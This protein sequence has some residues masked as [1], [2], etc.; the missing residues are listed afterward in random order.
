M[1]ILI[2]SI[3]QAIKSTSTSTASQTQVVRGKNK[4]RVSEDQQPQAIQQPQASQ[5]SQ[6]SLKPKKKISLKDRRI[7]FTRDNNENEANTQDIILALNKALY[8]LGITVQKGQY[9]KTKQLSLELVEY[10]SSREFLA[11]KD[12]VINIVR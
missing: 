7:L 4:T 5:Q 6:A 12:Y 9:S 3:P 1:P 2:L 11:K 8:S 10:N